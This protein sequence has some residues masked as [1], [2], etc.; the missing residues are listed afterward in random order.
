MRL[1]LVPVLAVTALA[2]GDAIPTPQT[3]PDPNLFLVA[4]V[5][6]LKATF[7][8]IEQAAQAIQPGGLPPGLLAMQAGGSLGDPGLNKLA[9]KPVVIAVGPGAPLPTIVGL[10]PSTDAKAYVAAAI[11]MGLMAE[12][13]GDLVVVGQLPT[14]ID[15]G[16]ALAKDYAALTAPAVAAK[17]D[18]RLI[19]APSKVVSAYGPMLQGFMQMAAAQTAGDPKAAQGMAMAQMVWP[20]LTGVA[21]DFA[22]KQIDLFLKGDV[23]QIESSAA[24]A[25]GSILATML[26][27]PPV[28]LT[29]P[30][31]PGNG[32]IAMGFNFNASA[33]VGGI[34]EYA[35][36]FKADPQAGPL[37]SEEVIALI[38]SAA[39]VYSGTGSGA[40]GGTDSLETSNILGITDAAKARALAKQGLALLGAGKVGEMYRDLGVSMALKEN[41]RST[42]G[43][44]IDRMEVTIDEAKAQPGMKE[45]MPNLEFAFTKTQGLS[46]NVLANV[47]ALVA[48]KALGKPLAAQAA[49]P[50]FDGYLDCDLIAYLRLTMSIQAKAQP[51]IKPMAD[52]LAAAQPAPPILMAFKL[53]DGKIYGKVQLPLKAVSNIGMALAA[54][55]AGGRPGGPRPRPGADQNAY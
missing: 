50:G 46:S 41:V 24:A 13:V 34:A 33:V 42:G 11:G 21:K 48:G 22:A 1:A 5:P 36:K 9:A 26:V 30:P 53:A 31:I 17:A 8:R 39:G 35:V 6:D 16:K 27:A 19:V 55:N 52:A 32:C 40:V 10:V 25:P 15:L 2:A 37:F 51:L 23:L 4:V 54:G 7:G 49:F 18:I 38:R 45:M 29:R 14:A 47:D 43:Q 20:V 44:Q 12:A 28:G 3:L